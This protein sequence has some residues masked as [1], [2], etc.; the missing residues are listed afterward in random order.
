MVKTILKSIVSRC[1]TEKR[2]RGVKSR[3][4][5]TILKKKKRFEILKVPHKKFDINY[6]IKS[7]IDILI[8]EEDETLK[9]LKDTEES[10]FAEIRLDEEHPKYKQEHRALAIIGLK[11]IIYQVIELSQNKLKLEDAFIFSVIALYERYIQNTPKEL[12]KNE[13]I[14]SLFS[15]LIYMD[16][17]QNIGV[18]TTSFFKKTNPSFVLN[19]DMLN[20]VDLNLFPVKIYNYFDLFFLRISQVNKD[21]KI[22]QDYI[23][24]FKD[25]FTEINFY[26]S[27]HENSR[28][29]KPSIN[30]VSCLFITYVFI[31]NNLSLENDTI[32]AY[33][34]H[35]KNIL[36]YHDE[37]DYLFA[38]EIIKESKYVYDD[39]IRN[40]KVNKL[41]KEGLINNINLNCI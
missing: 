10:E 28:Y 38:R 2:V 14:K 26:I 24:I 13:M 25:V 27:F 5:Q 19:S 18:F 22:Y 11:D 35:Y 9:R 1:S 23:K 6:Y 32:K 41:C 4:K 12:T 29:K 20:V 16:K 34:N 30:F 17:F 8:S 21:D 33:I 3:T 37:N 31:K 7:K 40:L 39:L 15:C 36:E